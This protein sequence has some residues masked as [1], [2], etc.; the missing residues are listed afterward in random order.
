MRRLKLFPC[1]CRYEMHRDD[2]YDAAG[3]WKSGEKENSFIFTN[4]THSIIVSAPWTSCTL[5]WDL[6]LSTHVIR[7]FRS[8]LMKT[9]TGKSLR[10]GTPI[11]ISQTLPGNCTVTLT[12]LSC[13]L[14]FTRR[15]IRESF[16]K[17][18]SNTV[19]ST[20]AL[21][22]MDSY[23]KLLQMHAF[24]FYSMSICLTDS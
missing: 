14:V 16:G 12:G 18:E 3:S 22:I 24:Y 17:Q 7:P 15:A 4:W 8:P 1:S 6:N 9:R 13:T 5:G 2:G 11:Q 10:T 20:S 19:D 23:S 21:R